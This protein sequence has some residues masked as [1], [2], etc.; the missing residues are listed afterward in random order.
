MTKLTEHEEY[1]R[2]EELLVIRFLFQ[3]F[4]RML[5]SLSLER[6]LSASLDVDEFWIG[7]RLQGPGRLMIIGC[8]YCG[9]RAGNLEGIKNVIVVFDYNFFW[10]LLEK[11][12]SIILRRSIVTHIRIPLDVWI[13]SYFSRNLVWWTNFKLWE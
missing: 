2:M 12:K 4:H 5:R 10:E 7:L 11:K 9:P 8:E 1:E 3:R 13:S 6:I